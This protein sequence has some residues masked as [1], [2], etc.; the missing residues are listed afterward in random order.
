MCFLSTYR[1]SKVAANRT[2]IAIAQLMCVE[3]S[4]SVELCLVS[5][6]APCCTSIEEVK[7]SHLTS[8]TL[9]WPAAIVLKDGSKSMFE[10]APVQCGKFKHLILMWS[11]AE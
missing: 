8:H 4:I 6:P 9:M 3:G 7:I 5:K 1:I 2:L 11:N 10:N